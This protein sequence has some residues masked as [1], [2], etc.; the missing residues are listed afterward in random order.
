MTGQSKHRRK[1]SSKSSSGQS[2]DSRSGPSTESSSQSAAPS[3]PQ[4]AESTQPK[5]YSRRTILGA[6]VGGAA[7]TGFVAAVGYSLSN[8]G[9]PPAI[10]QTATTI[11]TNTLTTCLKPTKFYRS[12]AIEELMEKLDPLLN[13][14]L[15]LC[16]G[17]GFCHELGQEC[18]NGVHESAKGYYL[19]QAR[20]YTDDLEKRLP[21]V[22]EARNIATQ[23]RDAIDAYTKKVLDFSQGKASEAD[24]LS[25]E[26]LPEF[27]AYGPFY[28][29]VLGKITKAEK[30]EDALRLLSVLYVDADRIRAREQMKLD[31]MQQL[32]D[33]ADLL[34]KNQFKA[35]DESFTAGGLQMYA[36]YLFTKSVCDQL[37]DYEVEP[38]KTE[39]GRTD[40]NVVLRDDLPKE[41]PNKA[42][43]PPRHVDL[44]KRI[45]G[46]TSDETRFYKLV[47]MMPIEEALEHYFAWDHLLSR[48]EEY[49]KSAGKA[50]GFSFAK[51][52]PWYNT[53]TALLRTMQPRVNTEH[54]SYQ[55]DNRYA[56]TEFALFDGMPE[57]SSLTKEQLAAILMNAI[58]K[59]IDDEKLNYQNVMKTPQNDC[60]MYSLDLINSGSSFE[61]WGIDLKLSNALKIAG[62]DTLDL[63]MFFEKPYRIRT[64]VKA[65]N[66]PGNVYGIDIR[67]GM[68]RMDYIHQFKK[69]V[70]YGW[71]MFQV[72]MGGALVTDSSFRTSQ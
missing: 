18:Q 48:G 47:G 68:P 39:S 37:R 54:N 34:I 64:E 7:I 24:V 28:F 35:G 9:V 32:H 61:A 16:V 12:Q 59:Q 63:V 26:L 13:G 70:P 71:Q 30:A 11:L 53:S 8:R 44:L 58:G 56:S 23:L 60:A 29:D 43:I 41:I 69:E 40:L 49:Q 62:V 57:G 21:S 14:Q 3:S 51:N 52:F 6:A 27:S 1:Q 55:T 38:R 65:P 42:M 72:R 5:K 66:G 45:A 67:D 20:F 22:L 10:T 2:T 4:L 50:I 36:S 33:G 25:S 15:D 19:Q 31:G 46:E 17:L